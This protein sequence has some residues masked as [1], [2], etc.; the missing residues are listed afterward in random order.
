MGSFFVLEHKKTYT[1]TQ[2]FSLSLSLSPYLSLHHT[3]FLVQCLLLQLIDQCLPNSSEAIWR[4]HIL[5]VSQ[6]IIR[7]GL[8]LPL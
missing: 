3:Q 5:E 6:D 8:L 1:L 2:G 7:R 4:F